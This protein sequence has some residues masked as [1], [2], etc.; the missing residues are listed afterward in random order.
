V[1]LDGI[2]REAARRAEPLAESAKLGLRVEGRG[3]RV[4]A[5][6]EWLEQ[7]LLVVIGNAVR[8]SECGSEIRLHAENSAV[9]VEDEGRGIGKDDLPHVFERFY[10]GRQGQQGNDGPGGFGLGLAICKDLVERMGGSIHL[11]SEE[12][13]GTKVMIELPEVRD[14]AEDSDS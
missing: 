9:M 5:D 7:A 4:W 13:I 12:G 8:H 11:N 2:V 10:Q 1:D 14:G 6:Y 3:G